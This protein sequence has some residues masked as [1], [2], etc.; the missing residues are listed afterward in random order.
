[1]CLIYYRLVKIKFQTLIT[2]YEFLDKIIYMK[3][4]YLQELNNYDAGK[5]LEKIG[6]DSLYLNSAKRKYEFKTLKFCKLKAIEANILKQTALSLSSDC[7]VHRNVILNA[8]GEF[9]CLISASI[10]TFL[11]IAEKLKLQQFRLKEIAQLIE[12]NILS[13]DKE[14]ILKIR[15]K[16]L[17]FSKE[18]YLMGILNITPDSFSDGGKYFS[19]EKA[20]EQFKSL[21]MQDADIIDIGAQSTKPNFKEIP[22]TEEIER[23]NLLFKSPEYIN[24]NIIKSIDTFNYQTAQFALNNGCDIINDISGFKDKN[25]I[26]LA[27]DYKTPLILMFNQKMQEKSNLDTFSQMYEFFLRKIDELINANIDKNKIIIDCGFGFFDNNAENIKILSQ[28]ANLQALNCPILLGISRKSFINNLNIFSD[29]D[30]A[31]MLISSK[32]IQDI[33]ILRVHDVKT[34]KEMLNLYKTLKI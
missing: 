2:K 8:E 25:M 27:A 12:E 18:K 31:S 1:M 34:H 19:H 26:Q 5:E 7:A 21:I 3:K 32:Y 9:D 4:L 17:N 20:E 15:G 6:F 22:A 30:N 23:L 14:K 13:N 29:L 10:S 28:L 24:S 11:K 33:N 16:E